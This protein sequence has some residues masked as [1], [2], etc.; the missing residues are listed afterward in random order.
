[1]SKKAFV[2]IFSIGVGNLLLAIL[3]I[4]VIVLFGTDILCYIGLFGY[5]LSMIA[6][7]VAFVAGE[8]KENK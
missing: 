3:G 7:L 8:L 4:F 2:I 6:M 5:L 1:M